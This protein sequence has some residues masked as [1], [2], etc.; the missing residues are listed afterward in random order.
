LKKPLPL[1]RS[2]PRYAVEVEPPTDVDHECRRCG[3]REGVRTVC[4]N[5]EGEPGGLLLVGMYPGR[6]EDLR[7]RPMVG[8]SGA[9]LRKLVSAWWTGPVALTNAVACAPG[10]REVT[11][12]HVTA[13]RTYLSAIVREVKPTRIVSLG[14]V[15]SLGL[16]GRSVAPLNQRRAYAWFGGSVPVLLL[17]NPAA[18]LRNR[19]VRKAFEDDL[20]WALTTAFEAPRWKSLVTWLVEDE[21]IAE[22]AL[23]AMR[24]A[25]TSWDVETA[26]EL[27]SESFRLLSVTCTPRGSDESFTWTEKSLANERLRDALLGWLRD[28]AATKT[29]QNGK[30]D[31]QCIHAV[32]GFWPASNVFDTR[33]GRKLLDPEGDAKLKVMADLVGFGGHKDEMEAAKDDAIAHVRRRLSQERREAKSKTIPLAFMKA[34][35][36]HP[37]ADVALDRFIRKCEGQKEDTDKWVMALVPKP[38]LYVYNGRDSL[39]TDVL[40]AHLEQRLAAQPDLERTWN[41]LVQPASDAVAQVEAWGVCADRDGIEAFDAYLGVEEARLRKELDLY[42]PGLNWGSR[43]QVAD[44]LY[45]KLGLTP[46]HMTETGKPSTD[47]DAMEALKDKHPAP[48][49]LVGLRGVNKLRSNYASG[50][51]LHVRDDG[52]IHTSFN[53]DGA[54]SGRISSSD[55]N[56]QNIPSE[57]TD[58][59]NGRM[60]RDVFTVPPGYVMVSH[61]YKQLELCVAAAVSGDPAMRAIFAAGVDF[62]QRAAEIAAPLMGKRVEDVTPGDRRAA[63]TVVFGKMYGRGAKAIAAQI[64][65]SVA[66]AETYINAVMGA[67]K[68]YDAWSK[69]RVKEART[70]GGVWVM[71]PHDPTQRG[72]FRPLWRIADKDD[73]QRNTAENASGNTPIQGLASDYCLASLIEVVRWIQ[74]DRLEERAKVVLTVHDQLVG[75]VREDF[76]GTY[77]ERVRSI[78]T[79]W[80]CAVPLAV[81]EEIGTRWGSL[82]KM[83]KAA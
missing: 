40:G 28:P 26:G 44:F 22:E 56:L 58:P 3:L 82:G 74:R 76:V 79:S 54:R 47:E 16:L 33:L 35:P 34:D 37:A 5:P 20:R 8:D 42:A 52:R 70:T 53:V 32:Y 78:M 13:C 72:R 30:Y 25:R 65:C 7:A 49:A 51:S 6:E 75:E 63:K 2:V 1:Y 11:D 48:A 27:Y 67:F 57:K 59:V 10:A 66:E 36:V 31:Q 39:V 64:G 41:R 69:D 60:A 45:G 18:A 29:A 4:M 71:S 38:V 9:Y 73:Q 19:F 50:M 43:D 24:S 21:D 55:P 80:P 83:K 81:D 23:G 14:D 68:V 12:K 77:C 15:A 62:H 46:P 17:C 61:D